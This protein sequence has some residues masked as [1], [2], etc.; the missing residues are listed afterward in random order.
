MAIKFQLEQFRRLPLRLDRTWLGGWV[1]M[2][3]WIDEN[4]ES[5]YQPMVCFWMSAQDEAVAQPDLCKPEEVSPSRALD[6]LIQFALDTQLGGYR[7]GEVQVKDPEL[8][9]YLSEQLQ[10]M[11]ISVS[12]N[13]SLVQLD[14][15]VRELGEELSSHEDEP[16]GSLDAKGVT[17]EKMRRFAEAAKLFYEAAPWQHLIDEDLLAIESP[18]AP[19][20][21]KYAS[22]LGAGGQTFGL[23]F[24]HK[25]DD[26]WKTRQAAHDLEPWLELQKKGVWSL[27]YSDLSQLPFADGDLWEDHQ[28][29]VA[30][31]NAYPGAF[32]FTPGQPPQRPNAKALAY[33]EGLLRALAA[34]SESQI[35]SGRWEMAV[36]TDAGPVT[37]KLALPDLVKPPDTQTWVKRGLIP[38]RRITEMLQVQVH[39]MVE[40]RGIE[41]ID[42][43]NALIEKEF[44]GKKIDPNRFAPR[45]ALEEAQQICHEAFSAHGRRQYQ[46]TKKA[47]EVSPDCAEAYILLAERCSNLQQSHDYYEQALA[48]AQRVLDPRLLEEA[49]GQFWGILETRPY[50]RAKFGLGQ[51]LEAMGQ[52]DAALGHYRE[53]LRLNPNDNQGV[54]EAYLPLLLKLG[55]DAEA[56]RYIKEAP[57]EDSASRVYIRALLAYRLGGDSST[58]RKELRRAVKAN[59]FVVPCLLEEQPGVMPE[60]YSLG[61]EEEAMVCAEELWPVIE[62]TPGALKWLEAHGMQPVSPDPPKWKKRKRKSR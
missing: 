53:L 46:L 54:R 59:P 35:D 39:R 11:G 47:L 13:D 15:I 32:K 62:V 37:Y 10:G 51:T 24:Y 2:P 48:V 1:K 16:P 20:G 19:V 50:M 49:V 36:E 43:M 25:P 45:N 34:T 44:M 27:T 38:D 3:S 17:V 4:S 57:D 21:L 6:A 12:Y 14:T 55:R 60:G 9:Q 42:E 8:A 7:P 31:P 22:I 28:L 61:S 29:P 23:G 40:E 18:R 56:A 58:S 41:D 5:P 30:G 26:L 33:L 52:D